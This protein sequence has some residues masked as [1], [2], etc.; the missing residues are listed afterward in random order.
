VNDEKINQ[1]F[2]NS[3]LSYPFKVEDLEK[4]K[5][6]VEIFIDYSTKEGQFERNSEHEDSGGLHFPVGSIGLLPVIRS[7]NLAELC[8]VAFVDKGK[9]NMWGKIKQE[10]KQ[11]CG[12]I[13]GGE[14]RKRWP[15]YQRRVIFEARRQIA[16]MHLLSKDFEHYDKIEKERKEEGFPGNRV[17]N[18]I[19][20]EER[21]V[22][23]DSTEF[24]KEVRD[25]LKKIKQENGVKFPITR[26]K[27][28]V[29]E[30]ETREVLIFRSVKS[31]ASFARKLFV[32]NEDNPESV[33]DL[34]RMWVV[35]L[36]SDKKDKQSER[37]FWVDADNDEKSGYKP[38]IWYL[39]RDPDPD[40][41][42]IDGEP[43]KKIA[44][45]D[46]VCVWAV[47]DK[48]L[49]MSRNDSVFPVNLEVNRIKPTP[50][51]GGRVQSASVGGGG[52]VQ[53]AKFY[54]NEN[55]RYLETMIFLSPDKLMEQAKDHDNNY[56]LGRLF[57]TKTKR[58]IVDLL[59][60][61]QIYGLPV[62]EKINEHNKR[63]K[64]GSND[65]IGKARKG[66]LSVLEKKSGS[67]N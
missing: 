33:K 64:D 21:E 25:F 45:T 16:L 20:G 48:A 34:S 12:D 32:K 50:P 14:F 60:P 30:S 6:R 27:I 37:S 19:I 26:G 56:S 40:Q 1:N 51:P 59:F 7:M 15:D 5:H 2:C 63:K 8:R 46:S 52:K 54:L 4:L 24:S 23:L 55:G 3:F 39:Y 9:N 31:D 47:L 38:I 66:G 67:S 35:Y 43:I 22:N 10:F 62:S 29:G 44:L 61:V 42:Q 41:L 53:Y 65:G 17:F 57:D 13:T 49:D 11:A 58:S 28:K 18:E 36:P